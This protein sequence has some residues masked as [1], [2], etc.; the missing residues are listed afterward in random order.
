MRRERAHP[1]AAARTRLGIVADEIRGSHCVALS[2][3]E[4]LASI[5]IGYANEVGPTGV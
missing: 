2:R 5:L 3:P 1:S 4:A